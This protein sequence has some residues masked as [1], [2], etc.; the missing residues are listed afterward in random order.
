MNNYVKTISGV[1]VLGAMLIGGNY[2]YKDT[3]NIEGVTPVVAPS[4]VDL[5]ISDTCKDEDQ[6]R[7]VPSIPFEVFPER[8]FTMNDIV[9][10]IDREKENHGD[11][12]DRYVELVNIQT[13]AQH[14][15]D[16]L[17]PCPDG[18]V[19]EENFNTPDNTPEIGI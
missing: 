5:H 12:T 9:F 1:I 15:I 6:L 7:I 13:K 16:T 14:A 10:E 18:R 17:P 8:S 11:Q 3:V 2:Y 19:S 4:D